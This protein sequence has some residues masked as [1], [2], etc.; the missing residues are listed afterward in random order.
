MATVLT[1]GLLTE[2]H[3]NSLPR[4]P[5]LTYRPDIDGLR[6]FAVLSVLGFHAN[7][8][9]VPGGYI[10]VDIFFVISGFL[11]T[12]IIC[13]NL[14][15]GRFTFTDFYAR[16][17]KRIFPSLIV[18][19]AAAWALG[20]FV[21]LT[22]EY[23]Q[24]G[25]HIAAGAGFISNFA[26]W[27]E[28]GYFD[29]AA[30][31]K[32]LL[33]LWSLGMEE[34][35]YLLWPPLIVWAWKRKANILN[36]TC[37]IVAASFVINVILVS[38]LQ[39]ADAFYLPPTRFWELLAG[40]ALGYAHLFRR[41]ELSRLASLANV[42]A[43][44]GLALLLIA[45]LA[46]NGKLFFP[47][48]WALLPTIGA[49]LLINAGPDAWINRNVFSS[50]PAVFV[51]L[52]SYSLYLWH[53]PLLSFAYI[54]EAGSPSP[55]TILGALVLAFVLAWLTYLIVEKPIR[56]MPNRTAL[57]LVPGLAAC[58]FVGLV[59]VAHGFHPRSERYG[60]EKIIAVS[61]EKAF[62]GPHLRSVHTAVGYHWEQ[63]RTSETVLFVG[64]SNVEQYYP[65]IDKILT[66]HPETTKGVLF[67]TENGCAP[68]P[69]MKEFAQRKC[70]GLIERAVSLAQ[71]SHVSAVVVAARWIGYD[72]FNDPKA[73][74]TA[75]NGLK[76]TLSSFS[77]PGRRVYL[78][79]PIPARREFDPSYMVARGINKIGFEIRQAPVHREQVTVQLA[80]IKSLLMK[81]AASAGAFT[82]D[83]LEDLCGEVYCATADN[84]GLPVY[85][86]SSHLRPSYAREHVTFLD[87][88]ISDTE[89]DGHRVTRADY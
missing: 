35:F 24:L 68:I 70:A 3:Q 27:Q 18:V 88:I 40:G 1:D 80:A 52:I 63:G 83:P 85:R 72:V 86:D 50:R 84:D 9:L 7:S 66:E 26:L 25:K 73:G 54:L 60:L 44:L 34:Q 16:R 58:A 81:V 36:M 71:D 47:G 30:E 21:L 53:W 41:K 59:T 45:I 33:H 42:Q 4:T 78:V 23:Q 5:D 2:S 29:K 56:A 57:V 22:D 13:R 64:D 20:W 69:Y 31:Y 77:Q 46:L 61:N 37:G 55:A 28:S 62:P 75:L 49:M 12:S 6:A 51:G 74:D 87:R 65:R 14:E 38:L 89:L 48:W 8:K 11:I 19:L 76:T 32:P 67:V 10:G 79:L 15:R 39:S 82:L 43:A 17:A